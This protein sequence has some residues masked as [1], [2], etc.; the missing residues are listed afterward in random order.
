MDI[1]ENPFSV[2][3]ATT[4][5]N[6]RRIMELADEKN[7]LSDGELGTNACSALTNPRRRLAAEIGWLPGLGPRR[8]SEM[9]ELIESDF[10]EIFGLLNVSPLAHTN[11]MAAAMARSLESDEAL[12]IEEWVY[13]LVDTYEEIDAESVMSML[14]EDRE[15]AG[16]PIITDL[17]AVEMELGGRRQHYVAVLKAFYDQLLTD[18]MVEEL[19]SVVETV[20]ENG[21]KSAPILIDDLVDSFEV[22]AQ[23]FLERET[24][25]I[26][27]LIAQI[28]T[29]AEDEHD[30][31][32]LSELVTT[33]DRVVKNWDRVAQPIQVSAR[34]RGLDHELSH[35][36]AAK[37]RSVAVELFNEHGHLNVSQRL[38]A[39][40]QEVFAEVDSVVEQTTED[41]AALDEIAEQRADFLNNVKAHAE[42]WRQEI[43]YE[44]DC[45]RVFKDKLKISPD[46]IEWKGQKISL[47][48][49]S[50]TRWGGTRHSVNGIPTG[51]TF[52]LY[53]GSERGEISIN[54]KQERIYSEFLDR[55]WKAVGTRILTEMLEGLRD[56]KRHHFG[57][58]VVDDYGV[59]FER[60]RLFSA[61]EKIRC[62]WLDLTIGNADGCFVIT[63]K[64]ERKVTAYLPYQEMD[65]VHVLEAAIRV[66]WKRTTEKISDLLTKEG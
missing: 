59:E 56:G 49:I 48:S 9:V 5:D 66:F 18:D 17:N 46:G 42:R 52:H 39:I 21:E 40:N 16:F 37:I 1:L 61:N 31:A 36:V 12:E 20:T 45:G 47:E 54:L 26:S 65:N 27:S 44:A 13:G 53:V 8:V 19:A 25:N 11:L 63:K 55:L 51:T 43:S 29:V 30:E 22:D 32:E 4:R 14:N 57:N 28:R 62:R 7:L 3:G 23:E 6:R 15:V 10:K 34:S 33:L 50:R 24:K 2:L 35:N 64:N 38:T 58:L 60:S 41:S